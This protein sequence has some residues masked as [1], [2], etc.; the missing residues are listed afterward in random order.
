MAFHPGK[1]KVMRISRATDK[2]ERDYS[3]RGHT[4]EVISSEKYLGVTI[5][6]KLSWSQQVKACAGN[7]NSKLGFLRRNIKINNPNIKQT[8]YRSLCRSTLEYGCSVWSPHIDDQIHSLEKV[9]RRAARYVCNK[10]KQRDSPT[11]MMNQMKWKSL[12]DRRTKSR[13]SMTYK[14][15]HNYVDIPRYK[16]FSPLPPLPVSLGAPSV[17]VSTL[18]ACVREIVL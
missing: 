1:C 7:G 10:N 11:D 9:Q 6:D 5:D 4:L 13:L 2:I 3:L 14:I 8:A 17:C 12:E 18:L 15:M 16:F